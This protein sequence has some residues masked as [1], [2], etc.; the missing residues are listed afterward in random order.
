[1][2]VKIANLETGCILAKD[3]MGLSSFPIIPKSTVLTKQHLHVLQAFSIEDVSVERVKIDGSSFHPRE[4]IEHDNP[5]EDKLD[6][7]TDFI[8]HYYEVVQEYKKEFISWQSG[9]P[10]NIARIR[11]LFLPL[12]QHIEKDT[13]PIYTI[14]HHTTKDDYVFHH[15][16]AVGLISGLIAKKL[17]YEQGIYLQ[18]ALAGLLADCGM[19]KVSPRILF[20][21][22]SLTQ[23][24]FEEIKLH[25][26][27]SYQMVKDT[28]FLKPEA[29]LAIFQHHERMDG[30]GYPRSEENERIHPYSQ[31]IAVAD[32]FHAMTS[33]KNYRSKQSPLRVLEMIKEDS[34]G[35]FNITV[36]NGILSLLGNLPK[37]TV[38]RLTDGQV[39][40]VIFTRIEEPTRPL[41]KIKDTE[42]IVDLIKERSLYIDTIINFNY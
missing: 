38:I 17:D 4:M 16:I 9:V 13:E 2:K 7:K 29:K 27:N 20:K 26:I 5:R 19:A 35:K 6:E 25:T 34:F 18:I 41:V 14:T 3:V 39:A 28:P 40:E 21:K 37:G 11:G 31:I 1:M 10:I 33:E 32:M 30:S 12:F 36:V 42:Q 24:E 15:G 8:K 22:T 23:K